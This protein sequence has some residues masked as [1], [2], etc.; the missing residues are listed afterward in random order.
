MTT[1]LGKTT[2]PACCYR[3]SRSRTPSAA[4]NFIEHCLCSATSVYVDCCVI[5]FLFYLFFYLQI[6]AAECYLKLVI[7]GLVLVIGG[8][9]NRDMQHSKS[10]LSSLAPLDH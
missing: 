9:G 3:D 7:F 5:Y 4:T 8:P 2:G 10:M 1:A 6:M